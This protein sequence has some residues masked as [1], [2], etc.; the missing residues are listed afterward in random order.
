MTDRTEYYKNYAQRPDVKSKRNEASKRA[1]KERKR[2]HT[3][4][5]IQEHTMDELMQIVKE[6]CDDKGVD[7]DTVKDQYAEFMSF[8]HDPS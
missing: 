5:R 7:Y 2:K 3:R 6:T 1:S 8:L 4:V